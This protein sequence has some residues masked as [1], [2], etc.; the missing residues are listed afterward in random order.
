[1]EGENM[2]QA[3]TT[4]EDLEKLKKKEPVE[5]HDPTDEAGQY[6]EEQEEDNREQI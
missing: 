4:P 1:M 3:K 5:T 2:W 6:V